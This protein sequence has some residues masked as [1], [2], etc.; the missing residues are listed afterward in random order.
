MLNSLFSEPNK[1]QYRDD[2][3]IILKPKI[4]E[5]YN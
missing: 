5:E 1:F 2:I 3:S 4:S